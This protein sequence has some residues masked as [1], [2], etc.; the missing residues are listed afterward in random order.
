ML[1]LL[2][3]LFIPLELIR[4]TKTLPKTCVSIQLSSL[5]VYVLL[6][7]YLK[8]I[9]A[10]CRTSLHPLPDLAFDSPQVHSVFLHQ[11]Y[12]IP[13][14]SSSGT[15][16][17]HGGVPVTFQYSQ[18]FKTLS[19]CL[20]MIYLRRISMLMLVVYNLRVHSHLSAISRF[21][22]PSPG[23]A[24]TGRSPCHSSVIYRMRLYLVKKKIV[25][26]LKR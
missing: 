7:I 4:H 15:H 8:I 20:P 19:S 2:S 24:E 1:C 6:C 17:Q 3:Q 23:K 10:S 22:N 25:Q 26:G 13:P 16:S 9:F 5:P 12:T 21:S 11:Q 18:W 14:F